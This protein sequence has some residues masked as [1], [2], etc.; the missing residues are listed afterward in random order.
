MFLVIV[1]Q[2]KK[3]KF[4]FQVLV[5]S[6]GGDYVKSKWQGIYFP[7]GPILFT[8]VY[9]RRPARSAVAAGPRAEFIDLKEPAWPRI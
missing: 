3:K 1:L 8:R 4:R 6:P 9:A 7:T 2:L 5:L